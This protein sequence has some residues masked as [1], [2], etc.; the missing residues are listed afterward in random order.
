MIGIKSI[1]EFRVLLNGKLKTVTLRE[2]KASEKG[3]SKI[4][5][6]CQATLDLIATEVDKLDLLM[7]KL[8]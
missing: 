2:R 3:W 6:G 5:S 4:L 1:S 7:E 8:K